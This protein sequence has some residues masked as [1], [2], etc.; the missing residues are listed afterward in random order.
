MAIGAEN[1]LQRVEKLWFSTDAVILRAQT[2]IFRVFA[3]ILKAKSS[4]FASMFTMPKPPSSDMETMDGV[5]V[6]TLHDDPD[7]LEVFLQAIFDSE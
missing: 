6:V 5:P 7:D 4:V 1:D 2:R 3:A